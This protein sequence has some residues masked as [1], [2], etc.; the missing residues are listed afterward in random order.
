VTTPRKKTAA[1][2]S[3]NKV[4]EKEVPAQD[5]EADA[6]LE[7]D[8]ANP[9]DDNVPEELQDTETPPTP[10]DPLGLNTYPDPENVPHT[11]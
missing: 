3:A 11:P 10:Q 5:L 6:D 2:K 1:G 4:T 9:V 8:G 7:D